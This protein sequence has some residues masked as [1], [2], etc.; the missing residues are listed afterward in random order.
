MSSLTKGTSRNSKMEEEKCKQYRIA[1]QKYD[2]TSKG[3]NQEQEQDKREELKIQ[4]IQ[5]ESID[6]QHNI[7][8]YRQ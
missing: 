2:L 5:Q 6:M 8:W 3:R 1:I 7:L 4:H